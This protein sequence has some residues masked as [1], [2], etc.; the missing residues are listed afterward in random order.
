M[1]DKGS[2]VVVGPGLIKIFGNDVGTQLLSFISSGSLVAL[3]ISP[4]F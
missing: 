3:I 1:F 4:L 2:T